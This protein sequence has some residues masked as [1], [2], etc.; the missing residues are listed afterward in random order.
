MSGCIVLSLDLP[1][2]AAPRMPENQEEDFRIK[3]DV[4]HLMNK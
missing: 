3:C 2:P 1:V 4:I